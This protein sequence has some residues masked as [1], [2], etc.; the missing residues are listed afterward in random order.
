MLAKS[1]DVAIVG[2]TASAGN[3][4]TNILQ[5]PT[6]YSIA[7]KSLDGT[8]LLWNEGA[9]CPYGYEPEEVIGKANSSSLHVPEDVRASKPREILNARVARNP[10]ASWLNVLLRWNYEG[11]I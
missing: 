7:G 8:I 9:R 6:E 5:S 2:D 1:L 4:F 11:T 3:I 10:W